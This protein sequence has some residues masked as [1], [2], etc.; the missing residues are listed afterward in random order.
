M[1]LFQFQQVR[2]RGFG[3]LEEAK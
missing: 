3:G 1:V 2:R